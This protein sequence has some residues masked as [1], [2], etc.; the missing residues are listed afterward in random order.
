MFLKYKPYKF[1]FLAGSRAGKLAAL[2]R[3]L[4]SRSTMV[5]WRSPFQEK[6]YKFGKLNLESIFSIRRLIFSS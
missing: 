2:H 4:I 3:M 5:V 1:R 6:N